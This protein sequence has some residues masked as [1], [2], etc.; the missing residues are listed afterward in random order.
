MSNRA[1][2]YVCCHP[3]AANNAFLD[4]RRHPEGPIADSLTVEQS[5]QGQ[6]WNET[7][8]ATAVLYCDAVSRKPLECNEDVICPKVNFSL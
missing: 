5:D 8:G 4:K 2:F 3:L 1:G 7:C 6:L